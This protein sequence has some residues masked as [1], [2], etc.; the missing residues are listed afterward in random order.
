MS[1][2]LVFNG[3]P[4]DKIYYLTKPNYEK[5]AIFAFLYNGGYPSKESITITGERTD[6]TVVYT[7]TITPKR[8]FQDGIN[9]WDFTVADSGQF[10]I[11]LEY[12]GYVLYSNTFTITMAV[13]EHPGY[14]EDYGCK[15]TQCYC[16][17]AAAIA[18]DGKTTGYVSFADA[19]AAAQTEE[20]KDC[21]LQL[22]ADTN[23][24]FTAEN[25]SFTLDA[26][27]TL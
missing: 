17:L 6:G 11:K 27:G 2:P 16:D 1:A 12:N 20:N 13:C 4:R 18:K 9:L 22:L 26:G 3:Q 24:E 21:T 19:L 14:Y 7:N 5:W 8:I 23:E 10:R 25:G 15:C